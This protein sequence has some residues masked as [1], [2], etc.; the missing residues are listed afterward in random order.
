METYQWDKLRESAAQKGMASAKGRENTTSSNSTFPRLSP[1]V[2]ALVFSLRDVLLPVNVG[3][4]SART[5][6]RQ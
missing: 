6:D 1:E 3:S 5:S 4:I 2:A